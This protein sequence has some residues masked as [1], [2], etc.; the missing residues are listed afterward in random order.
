MLLNVAVYEYCRYLSISGLPRI[1]C[2]DILGVRGT[3]SAL[4]LLG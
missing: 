1:S 3:K 4:R 2:A